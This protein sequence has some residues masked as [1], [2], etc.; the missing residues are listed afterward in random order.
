MYVKSSFNKSL[1]R[2]SIFFRGTSIFFTQPMKKQLLL[3]LCILVQWVVLAQERTFLRGQ[4][5]YL[6]TPVVSLNVVNTTTEMGTIT[7]AYGEYAIEVK[8]GD[9]LIFTAVNYQLQIVKITEDVLK[10]GR[11][12]V[13]VKEKVTELEEVVVTP[14][15]KEA[16]IKL[17][18]NELQK[19]DYPTDHTA[20]VENLALSQQE[21]GL[22]N[23]INFVAIGKM[24]FRA[25]FPK[26]ENEK[27]ESLQKMLKP[28]EV[29]RTVYDDEFFVLNL[30]I[31]Q[32]NIDEFLYYCDSKFPNK[33]LLKK[34]NEFELVDFLVKQ[35]H[36]YLEQRNGKE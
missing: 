36:H 20:P 25:I 23:G 30:K 31:P 7:N 34:E 10:K 13:E 11:L 17:K 33:K 15:N 18:E 14:D 1:K 4:V 12:V 5:L 35:S 9:E 8:V 22:Q 3:F 29:L 27:P 6:N 19:F 28:S 16:Y 21:R 2:F 24:L 26:K 32:E